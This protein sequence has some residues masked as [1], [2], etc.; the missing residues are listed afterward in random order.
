MNR[1][2]STEQIN[3]IAGICNQTYSKANKAKLREI[4]T[5][6]NLTFD[7]DRQTNANMLFAKHREKLNNDNSILWHLTKQNYA[8]VTRLGN[9]YVGQKMFNEYLEKYDLLDEYQFIY[10]FNPDAVIEQI[11]A[12]IRV[13]GLY[14]NASTA[15][16]FQVDNY[17]KYFSKMFGVDSID[18]KAVK[19]TKRV[20]KFFD[21]L[22]ADIPNKSGV[23]VAITQYLQTNDFTELHN[24]LHKSND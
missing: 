18:Q 19:A 12:L 2:L 16:L 4:G 7:Q 23:F 14:L 5:K 10:N 22:L 6:Y 20:S 3:Q 24:T 1:Y 15:E 21:E 13:S 17:E 9:N 8:E 11:N